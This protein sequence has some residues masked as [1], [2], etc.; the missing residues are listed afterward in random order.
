MTNPEISAWAS[1][2]KVVFAI[3]FVLYCGIAAVVS[4]T[5]GFGVAKLFRR[6]SGKK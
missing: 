1:F 5:G 3:S 4:V 6:L 2:W